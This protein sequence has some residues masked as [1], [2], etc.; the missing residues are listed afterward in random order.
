MG[1]I[2]A[3]GRATWC[4]PAVS[5][6]FTAKLR[7]L[8]ATLPSQ[9]LHGDNQWCNKR[10]CLHTFYS[11][12]CCSGCMTTSWC[13]NVY[14]TTGPLW[15]ESIALKR[16]IKTEL[17]CSLFLA[18]ANYRTTVQLPVIWDAI[19]VLTW[20]QCNAGGG[21]NSDNRSISQIPVTYP[22]MHHSVTQEC[23]HMCTF[24]LRSG[25]LWDIPD[26]MWD[27]WD[28]SIVFGESH[29]NILPT[30]IQINSGAEN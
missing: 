9:P 26:T 3:A 24:L 18:W 27:L 2:A 16:V 15:G 30:Y 28:G 6:S 25:A 12:G 11:H 4:N 21:N 8:I 13:G 14:P 17:W 5:S 19:M 29:Y 22:T 10:I 7:Y 23:V 20:R 1:R